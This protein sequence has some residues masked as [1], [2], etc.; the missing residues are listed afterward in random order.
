MAPAMHAVAAAGTVC[1]LYS[2]FIEPQWI[3]VKRITIQTEKL[4]KTRLK[5]VQIS[6]L[7]C[8]KKI[9]NEEKVV[10]IINAE[11]PDI[12]VFTGDAVNVAEAVPLFQNTL[13]QMKAKIGKYAVRGNWD[14]WRYAQIDFFRGTGFQSA[15]GKTIKAEKD[16]EIFFISGVSPVSSPHVREIVKGFPPSAFS[17]LLYHYPDLIEEIK[18]VPVDLYLSGHTHGGQVALPF[19][20]ALVTLS[21]YGK[22]Y[23]AGLYRINDGQTWLY[24]NRGLGVEGWPVPPLRFLA[25]PEVTVF[26]VEPKDQ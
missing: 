17:L 11:E 8:D 16:G 1:L 19:Y 25:R 5:I 21:R 12:V 7:H 4:K 24:V 6:D 26:T 14:T 9:R 18:D 13:R 20:G 3:E 22:K 15:E 2:A 23:E 10:R